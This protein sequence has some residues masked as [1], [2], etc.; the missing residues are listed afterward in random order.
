MYE[1]PQRVLERAVS[2]FDG[3]GVP[4]RGLDLLARPDASEAAIVDALAASRFTYL[5]GGSPLHL[6]AVVKD[7]PAWDA[8]GGGVAGGWGARRVLRWGDGAVRPDGR[9][10]RWRVHARPRPGARPGRDPCARP[11]VRRRR[12]P[13]PPDE[14]AHLVLAGIDERTA[15]IRAADGAWQRRGCGRG[16][17]VRGGRAGRSRRARRSRRQLTGQAP[18]APQRVEMVTDS[19]VTWP[20]GALR[21]SSRATIA[22]STSSPSVT[23]PNFT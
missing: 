14:P 20:R 12:P 2:W 16:G 10:A 22:S 19:T 6:R 17:G 11:L 15:L 9:P 5:V 4:A 7:S 18:V 23:W 8:L 3:L 1:H 21:P 13:H